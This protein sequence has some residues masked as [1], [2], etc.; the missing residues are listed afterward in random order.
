M[1]DGNWQSPQSD[2][3]CPFC[4]GVLKLRQTPRDDGRRSFLYCGVDLAAWEIDTFPA[5]QAAVRTVVRA[6]ARLNILRD[7]T[8]GR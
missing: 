5:A 2:A 8:C 7:A 1:A 3:S 4:G 6:S